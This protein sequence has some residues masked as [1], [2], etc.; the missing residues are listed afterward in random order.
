M[1]G[2]KKTRSHTDCQPVRPTK[3]D[4]SLDHY[5]RCLASSKDHHH[6][7]CRNLKQ[8]LDDEGEAER[9]EKREKHKE[10][11]KSNIEIKDPH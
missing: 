3:S 9:K 2:K 11:L 1:P 6:Y 10:N 8:H 5:R 4:S 7:H